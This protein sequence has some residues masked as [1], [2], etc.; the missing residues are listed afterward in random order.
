MTITGSDRQVGPALLDHLRNKRSLLCICTLLWLVAVWGCVTPPQALPPAAPDYWPMGG[1]R[2]STPEAQGMDSGLLAQAVDLVREQ[3]LAVDSLLIVRHGY[4]VLDAY[5]YPYTADHLHDVASV[6]KSIMSTLT[7]IAIE[8]GVIAGLDAPLAG[9][10]PVATSTSSDPRKARIAIRD[11]LSMSS[12][13]RCGYAP[14]EVELRA[15]LETPNWVQSL[16]DLPMAAEPGREFAYCSGNSHL[17]S[18]IIS[19][20]AHSTTLEF[21]QRT[22]FAPLGIHKMGW[23]TDPQGVNRG[24]GELQMTPRDLAKIG[25][26]FL[27]RGRWEDR[28]IVSADWVDRATRAQVPVPKSDADYGYGWWIHKGKYI[29]LY[30]AHGRGGQVITVAPALDIVAV[31]TGG[32]YDRE[33]FAPLLLAAVKSNKPLPENHAG[34]AQ[35]EASLAAIAR[36]HEP[37]PVPPL[38]ALARSISGRTYRFD[39]NPLGLET[40][41]LRFDRPDEA[42]FTLVSRAGRFVMPVGLDAVSRFSEAT[43]SGLAAGLKGAWRSEQE[44]ALR[45]DEIAGPNNFTLHLD[46]QGEQTNVRLDDPSGMWSFAVRALREPASSRRYPR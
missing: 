24:W 31:F 42:M 15:M 16:L 2:T 23:P 25:F 19:R 11:L 1:W 34:R 8:E 38:P 32:F 37:L 22:L 4:I 44:F 6:T 33:R 5:F 27:H 26:L 41:A 21:A 20:R 7:G 14:G 17:L 43:P 3:G 36:P 30:E 10:F 29:G 28:Q 13:L 18:A 39:A 45:Y 9:F 40:F 12:G 46:F 35:L